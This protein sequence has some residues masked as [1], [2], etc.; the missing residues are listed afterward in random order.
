MDFPKGT[1]SKQYKP[2]QQ[3]NNCHLEVRQKELQRSAEKSIHL[4]FDSGVMSDGSKLV[5]FL[6]PV[7]PFW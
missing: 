5:K 3:L 7:G 2:I 4:F 1:M 6:N